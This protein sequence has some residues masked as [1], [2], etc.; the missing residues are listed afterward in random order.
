MFNEHDA[1]ILTKAVTADDGT[2][3]VPGDV[4]FIIHIHSKG[5]AYVAEFMSVDGETIDIATVTP[6]HIRSATATDMAH[7]RET[8]PVN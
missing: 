3:L 5:K 6:D 7:S 1:I 2:E 8:S 4:G